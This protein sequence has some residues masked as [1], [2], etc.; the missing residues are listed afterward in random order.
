MIFA[1][2]GFIEGIRHSPSRAL[3]AMAFLTLA[4]LLCSN[5]NTAFKNLAAMSESQ[6][7]SRRAKMDGGSQL[8]SQASQLRS[9]RAAQ[10]QVAGEKAVGV[11]EADAKAVQL[12]D[13][14]RWSATSQCADVTAAQS[15]EYCRKVQEA[16]AKVEAAKKRDQLD[17]QLRVLDSKIEA[18]GFV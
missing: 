13:P 18:L 4:F 16:N 7:D 11:L 6:S 17:E 3:S 8:A 15:G 9:Q 14:R 1:A 12:T 5:V 2:A 10:V